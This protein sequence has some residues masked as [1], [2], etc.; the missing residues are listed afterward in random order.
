[1]I[2]NL[3]ELHQYACDLYQI[4]EYSEI[5][6]FF[7]C[8]FNCFLNASLSKA[9]ARTDAKKMLHELKKKM[10]EHAKQ[11][12]E[13]KRVIVKCEVLTEDEEAEC[14]MSRCMKETEHA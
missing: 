10:Q 5:F 3:L 6:I 2:Y 13:T 9:I 11:Q 1:M 14:I 7:Q 8:W 12:S 4:H